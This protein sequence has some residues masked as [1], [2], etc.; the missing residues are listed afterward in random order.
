MLLKMNASLEDTDFS[1]VNCKQ[2]IIDILA[3]NWMLAQA[4]SGVNCL[5]GTIPLPIVAGIVHRQNKL[6]G[7]YKVFADNAP[8]LFKEIKTSLGKAK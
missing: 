2:T 8:V 3:Y 7:W 4:A 1:V 5:D 6:N